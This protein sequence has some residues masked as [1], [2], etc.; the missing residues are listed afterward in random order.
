MRFSGAYDHHNALSEWRRRGEYDW[1]TDVF[2]EPT[3]EIRPHSRCTH[4]I[5]KH[6]SNEFL[7]NGWARDV[8]I[9][10]ATSVSVFALSE[11]LVFQL[12]TGN[13]SRAG[14]DL[15]KLQYLF[16]SKKIESAALAVPTK[17]AAKKI[18]SNIANA[19]RVWSELQLFS[20]VITVPILLIAFE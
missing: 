13:I 11:D 8:K 10:N 5:R 2:E 12:Q 17:E 7:N 14:Y 20:R 15:V 3:V 16:Q 4:A 18:G 9:S 6:V 19:D 1:V